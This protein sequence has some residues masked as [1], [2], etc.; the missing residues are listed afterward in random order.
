MIE[1]EPATEPPSNQKEAAEPQAPA[2]PAASVH[3]QGPPSFASDRDEQEVINFRWFQFAG[4]N[5]KAR[6]ERE[7]MVFKSV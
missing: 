1:A 5:R 4:P 3:Q 2:E 6:R 7:R